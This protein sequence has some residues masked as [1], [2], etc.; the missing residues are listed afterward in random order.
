VRLPQPEQEEPATAALA[1]PAH[2]LSVV[3][4]MYDERECV[5][6]ML[7]AVELALADYP[8]R[9]ELVVV[10][11]GSRDGTGEALQRE[12]ERRDNVRVVRLLRNHGQAAALQ[13]GFDEARGDVV[14]TLDGDLQ[15]DPRDIPRLVRLLLLRDLDL[16]VGWRRERQD[17]LLLR[18]LPSIAANRLVRAATGL[19]FHD[20]GCGL[21]AFRASVL[22]EVRLRGDMHRLVAAWLAT[23]TSPSRMA[24]E[25]VGHHPRRLGRS[26]YGL[27]RTFRVLVDLLVMRFFLRHRDRPAHFFGLAGLALSALGV[28]AVV[29]LAVLHL[30][31]AWPAPPPLLAA[32]VTCVVGGVQLL[33][34]AVLAE[35]LLRAAA[36]GGEVR[37]LAAPRPPLAHDAGWHRPGA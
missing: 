24:E 7:D 35:L 6:P 4:P 28:L 25:P 32:A 5:E 26:K 14:V 11:D 13:A 10:D 36:P 9:W 20:V 18:R 23:V 2:R 21:K 31:D 1:M 17:P 37:P 29:V 33:A 19:P 15:N 27:S 34:I 3:V 12:A 22:R 30:T 16:V 8:H